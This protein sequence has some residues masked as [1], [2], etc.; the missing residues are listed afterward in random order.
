MPGGQVKPLKIALITHTDAG[1]RRTLS[2]TPY[3]IYYLLNRYCGQVTCIDN[4]IPGSMTLR[5]T[6][7]NWFRLRAYLLFFEYLK[8]QF[9][10]I[11]GKRYDWRV[12]RGAARFCARQI[13]QRLGN[14]HY[15]LIWVEKSS[16]SMPLVKT[17]IPVIHE[18]DATFHALIDYY[19]WFTG[20]SWSALRNGEWLERTSLHK[21]AAVVLT[22][23]WAKNSAISDY[24]IDPDKITVLPS[25]PNCDHVPGR[26][27]V[28]ME[29]Q[30]AMCNLLFIGVD[31][32]RKGG[33]IAVEV[34]EALNRLGIPS[35]LHVCGCRPPVKHENNPYLQTI[36]FLDKNLH[37]DM[38]QWERLF[39]D[40]HFFILPTRAECMGISFSEAAGFGLP[41]IATDT[42]GVSTVVKHKKNGLLFRIDESPSAIA[43]NIRDLW[44]DRKRYRAMQVESRRFF[45]EEISGEVWIATV[46]R[47]IA[48]LVPRTTDGGRSANTA[49]IS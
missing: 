38:K 41:I 12:S 31:W 22:A 19:P 4:L 3:Q 35:R 13:E 10:R 47:I 17:D 20:L 37:N 30:T 32:E 24:G 46:R 49:R 7:A 6:I 1:D 36:G 23:D 28:L 48:Q 26:D 18:S 29:K 33:D 9:W 39:L 11:L 44:I 27:T 16:I 2:G 5:Y 42:G 15:D 45:D 25:P 43:E 34:V 14:E 21:A 8:G 40:A